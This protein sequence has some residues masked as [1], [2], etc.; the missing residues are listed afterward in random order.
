MTDLVIF[1]NSG[2]IDT[3]LISS[4]GVNVKETDNPIGYFGTGMKYALAILMRERVSVEIAVGEKTLK[5][6]TVDQTI[7][8]RSFSFITLNGEMLNFTTELGKNWELWMAYR[9]LYTNCIDEDGQVYTSESTYRERGTTKI[10]VDG[11][12]FSKLHQNRDQYFLEGTPLVNDA[13]VLI[14]EGGNT[15]I[16]FRNIRVFNLPPDSKSLFSYNLQGADLTEDRTLKSTWAAL[17]DITMA[18]ARCTDRDAIRRAITASKG[19]LERTLDYD[20]VY[21]KPSEEFLTVACQVARTNHTDINPTVLSLVKKHSVPTLPEA[22]ELDPIQEEMLRRALSF[23]RRAGFNIATWQIRPV[24]SLGD[25]TIGMAKDGV[26]FISLEAFETGVKQLAITLFE[27]FVHLEFKVFDCT[28]GMQ[29]RLL[30]I[31]AK[32][33]E[34]NTGEPL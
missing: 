10:I 5:V 19:T 26:I 6:G 9:E 7:R 34:K 8:G 33:V 1:E 3:R 2:E 29:E 31:I 22:I 15:A 28:R 13:D 18:W 17:R 14:H 20:Y 32:L 24:K 11:A 23:W 12:A 27:E 21:R 16:F 4:F 25:G 30:H